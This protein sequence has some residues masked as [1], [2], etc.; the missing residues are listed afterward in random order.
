MDTNTILDMPL[1]RLS[2]DLHD[3]EFEVEAS[4]PY[5]DEVD[6]GSGGFYFDSSYGNYLPNDPPTAYVELYGSAKIT[7]LCDGIPFASTYWELPAGYYEDHIMTEDRSAWVDDHE[8]LVEDVAYRFYIEE[9]DQHDR[10]F[11]VIYNPE[12]FVSVFGTNNI[13][14]RQALEQVS[15]FKPLEV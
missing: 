11:N 5:E 9:I 12:D 1:M 3:F 6:I 13:T 7:V 14:V 10:F 4:D 8:D 2:E 15:A